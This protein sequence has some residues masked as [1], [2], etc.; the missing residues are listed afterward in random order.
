MLFSIIAKHTVTCINR[1]LRQQFTN[2]KGCQLG[3][4]T[5]IVGSEFIDRTQIFKCII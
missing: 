5:I 4:L 1:S 2:R 3:I